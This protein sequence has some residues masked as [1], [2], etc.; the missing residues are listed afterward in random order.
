MAFRQAPPI[1]FAIAAATFCCAPCFAAQVFVVGE[2][3]A[4]ADVDADFHPTR[5]ELPTKP[6]DE[7]GRRELIRDLEAEQGFAHRALPLGNVVTLMANGRMTPSGEQYKQILYKKGQCAAP[8][9]R[10]AIT[11]VSFNKDR[12]L[13]DIDGGPYLKH[14][15]LRHVE[16]N[17]VPVVANNGE[18][19]TGF[20]VAL[21]FEGGIPE[22]SA[23]EVKA[24]LDPIIDFGVKN[25]GQ[26]YASTLPPFLKDAI[27]HHDILV[28]MNRRMV[29][30]SA[31]PPASK[32][33]ELV[34]GSDTRHYEE[35]IYGA[36]PQTVRFIR[37]E[38]DRVT[39]VR[40]AALGQPIAVKTDNELQ[41]YLDPLDE[42]QI[43]MGDAP[44]AHDE[45]ARPAGAPPTLRKPGDPVP[46]G[47][48]QKVQY[49]VSQPVQPLPA[50]PGSP[51]DPA[52]HTG[53]LPRATRP[54]AGGQTGATQTGA[55]PT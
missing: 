26:A 37:I 45:D 32:V 16:L 15:F 17:D 44:V 22:V 21:V 24:L 2:K 13:L 28:G 30:A 14:R 52:A 25:S 3:T 11:S 4:T 29:L 23:P 31:G 43:A 40:T 39:Q 41:G 6:L 18:Q 33:R 35:W 48:S 49:P 50:A 12:I 9:E 46:A 27:D 55:N 42:H 1:A 54:A 19:V 34:V 20:R 10:V 5:V 53:D 7:M 47:S 8:G 51:A 38:N 36:V